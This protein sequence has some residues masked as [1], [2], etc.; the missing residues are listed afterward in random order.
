MEAGHTNQGWSENGWVAGLVWHRP[1]KIHPRQVKPTLSTNGPEFKY[2]EGPLMG[3][4]VLPKEAGAAPDRRHTNRTPA[5]LR[6][7]C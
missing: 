4:E 1:P 7:A 5:R 2:C 6:A 3:M